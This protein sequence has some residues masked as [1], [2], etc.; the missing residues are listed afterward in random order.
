MS[1]SDLTYF[2]HDIAKVEHSTTLQ[3][4]G[5]MSE[6]DQHKL[7]PD[8]PEC[9]NISWKFIEQGACAGFSESMG[10]NVDFFANDEFLKFNFDNTFFNFDDYIFK[11]FPQVVTESVSTAF[12][13][14][15]YA[16]LHMD[17]DSILS[18]GQIMFIFE[19][20][21]KH[22]L[23]SIDDQGKQ[24]CIIPERGDIIFLDIACPHA[25][26]P[27]HDEYT[28]LNQIKP[29]KMGMIAINI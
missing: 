10:V 2:I 4:I 20:D 15:L 29:L 27:Y 19:N 22:T 13:E 24:H 26:I 17:G 7:L 18:R 5:V 14:A 9:D 28:D 23:Y 8:F 11:L 3:K 16:N 12:C 21:S 6:Q 1:S 25:L